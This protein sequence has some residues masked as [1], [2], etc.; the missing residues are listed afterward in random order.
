MTHFKSYLSEIFYFSLFLLSILI[1]WFLP[2]KD[3]YI[4]VPFTKFRGGPKRFIDNLSESSNLKFTNWN[5]SRVKKS[6]I[7]YKSWGRS[8]FTVSRSCDKEYIKS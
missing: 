8:Y 2:K 1:G 7:L 5:L 6:L 3:I 4:N